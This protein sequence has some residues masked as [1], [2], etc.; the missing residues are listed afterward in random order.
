MV[1]HAATGGDGGGCG[2]CVEAMVEA[3]A[4]ASASCCCAAANCCWSCPT[5][6]NSPERA[7]ARG[8]GFIVTGAKPEGLWRFK[9]WLVASALGVG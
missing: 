8:L 4:T 3:A 1:G 2:E 7:S 5:G 6:G 9:A